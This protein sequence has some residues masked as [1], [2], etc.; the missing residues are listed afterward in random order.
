MWSFIEILD[1]HIHFLKSHRL[2]ALADFISQEINFVF[3]Y[4][5]I[6]V[7]CYSAILSL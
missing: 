1:T 2:V 4:A 3:M 6:V 7:Y 5:F